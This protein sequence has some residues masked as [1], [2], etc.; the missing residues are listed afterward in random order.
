MPDNNEIKRYDLHVHTVYSED[1]SIEVEDALARAQELKL[2]GIAITDHNTVEGALKALDIRDRY[3]VEVVPG[4]EVSS[5]A[6]DILGLDVREGIEERDPQAVVAAIHDQG[7]LAVAPHPF[8]RFYTARK[9]LAYQALDYDL[10]GLEVIN[11][12][13]APKLNARARKLAERAKLSMTAGSDAHQIDH[14]GDAFTLCSCGLVEA[15]K[16]RETS[17]E[18]EDGTV[19]RLVRSTFVKYFPFSSQLFYASGSNL[20]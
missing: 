16:S 20:D 5:T 13:S 6:G 4:I 11:P 10:D 15:I 8:T 7:G 17:V 12:R 18:G 1:S 19:L 9:G 2:T 3:E 14:I